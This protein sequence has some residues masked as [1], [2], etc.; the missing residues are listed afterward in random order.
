VK[1]FALLVLLACLPR[2][3]PAASTWEDAWALSKLPPLPLAS[4]EKGEISI[5]RRPLAGAPEVMRVEAVFHLGLPPEQAARALEGWNPSRHPELE[6]LSH[7][8]TPSALADTLNQSPE[9]K[10]LLAQSRDPAPF[11]SSKAEAQALKAG[12]EEQ[13]AE[14]LKQFLANRAAL[15]REKGLDG[16]PA[17][18]TRNPIWQPGPALR[19]C[20]LS[21]PLATRHF[22]SLLLDG[23]KGGAAT[24]GLRR[25]EYAELLLVRRE[26]TLLLGSY[27]SASTPEG[28]QTVDFQHYV[29]GG[30]YAALACYQ[31]WP[32]GTG[33]VVWRSD[34]VFVPDD[35]E[36]KGIA[37]MAGDKLLAQEIRKA[38]GFL[39]GDCRN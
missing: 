29:S 19:R 31:F 18:E 1:R 6:V 35:L 25:T 14:T 3:S 15:F 28:W 26:P 32:A 37:A 39:Q 8:G 7:Q 4:L 27:L 10:S 33:S 20:L 24:P 2:H 23:I 12:A 17:Y 21:L 34:L 36:R 5:A 11:Q 9:G 16:L 30:F 22:H 38:I 13:P